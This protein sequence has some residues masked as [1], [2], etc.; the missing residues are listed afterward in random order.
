MSSIWGIFWLIILCAFV[1]LVFF[2][3]SVWDQK[4]RNKVNEINLEGQRLLLDLQSKP[5]NDL[6]DES[7]KSHGV[8]QDTRD[9]LKKE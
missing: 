6:I 1:M 2:I 7:N 4:K 8:G 5:I 3:K 9:L